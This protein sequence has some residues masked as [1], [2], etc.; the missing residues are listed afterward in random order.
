MRLHYLLSDQ[1]QVCSR[2]SVDLERPGTTLKSNHLLASGRGT[3]VFGVVAFRLRAIPCLNL[4]RLVHFSEVERPST[5]GTLSGR[6]ARCIKCT[7]AK[8]RIAVTIAKDAITIAA[9]ALVERRSSFRCGI[10]EHDTSHWGMVEVTQRIEVHLGM[11]VHG[12]S[13]ETFH[14]GA[15]QFSGRAR[16]NPLEIKPE[17]TIGSGN[18]RTEGAGKICPVKFHSIGNQLLRG[19]CKGCSF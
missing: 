2:E 18:F 8:I 17:S 16:S 6:H 3:N 15:W 19:G 11:N 5:G 14:S 1:Q 13:L 9:L 4:P 10:L 12:F 7:L